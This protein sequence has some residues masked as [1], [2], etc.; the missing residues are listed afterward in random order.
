MRILS[1]R[2]FLSLLAGK[3][4]KTE[5]RLLWQQLRQIICIK[6]RAT[7]IWTTTLC[8]QN[9]LINSNQNEIVRETDCWKAYTGMISPGNLH[10]FYKTFSA[11]IEIR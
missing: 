4:E 3:L 6:L 1:A 9:A 10:V 7:N 2:I 8:I 11:K 5:R